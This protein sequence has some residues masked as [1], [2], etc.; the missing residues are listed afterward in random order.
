[1][2]D[3]VKTFVQDRLGCTC[4]DEVFEQIR[5]IESPA[6]FE[7]TPVNAVCIIG[8]RLLIAVSDPKDWHGAIRRLQQMVNAGRA[9]RDSLGLNRFRLVI[10]AD[11]DAA[12]VT[13]QHVFD[14]LR[15][16]DDRMHLH[17]VMADILPGAF[18]PQ[19]VA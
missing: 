6:G 11:D 15:D 4:P 12:A 10:A 9:L 5:F 3:A 8:E 19:T 1:M 7:D 17:L 16:V 2:N 14:S 18:M 13:L